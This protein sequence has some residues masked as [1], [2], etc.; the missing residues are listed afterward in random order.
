MTVPVEKK[1]RARGER[2]SKMDTSNSN[3]NYNDN[4]NNNSSRHND[5]LIYDISHVLWNLSIV[6]KNRSILLI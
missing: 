4:K 1:K 6:D 5:S 2:P 3:Y